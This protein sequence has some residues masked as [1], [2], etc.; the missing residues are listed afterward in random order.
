MQKLLLGL[1]NFAKAT[2]VW[3][4][5][6]AFLLI[7]AWLAIID[8]TASAATSAGFGMILLFLANLDR[9]EYFKGFGLEAKTRELDKK[10]NE[11]N[12]VLDELK[13]LSHL[14]GS[15]LLDTV[16]RGGR[17]DSHIGAKRSYQL[18]HEI[19]A[20]L[21]GVGVDE[22]S[23]QASLE[24]WI[25]FTAFDITM[26]AVKELRAEFYRLKKGASEEQRPQVELFDKELSTIHLVRIGD[27]P[28]LIDRLLKSAP[29]LDAGRLEAIRTA[30]APWIEELRYVVSH[31]DLPKNSKLLAQDSELGL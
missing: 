14:S 25:K 26:E 6:V 8:K 5:A 20:Q 18:M 3:L 7:G 1:A 28:A 2:V 10:I 27:L 16:C 17:L 30:A 21:R 12:H 23:V 4:F 29:L 22:A 31:K 24:P 15:I 9:I 11:A 13:R 19:G